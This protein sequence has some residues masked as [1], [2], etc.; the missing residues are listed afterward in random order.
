[1]ASPAALAAAVVEELLGEA[2]D[3][4][5]G[6]GTG[7]TP[8]VPVGTARASPQAPGDG[9]KRCRDRRVNASR[10]RGPRRRRREGGHRST[11]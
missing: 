10:L 11:R 5:V 1:M 9:V 2:D 6:K 7:P 3:T 4:V 8:G